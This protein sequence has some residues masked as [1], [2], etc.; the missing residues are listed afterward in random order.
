VQRFSRRDFLRA[1]AA[2]TLTAPLILPGSAF[3]RTAASDRITM[4][5]IGVGG[6]GSWDM[7]AFL[8]QDAVQVVAVCDVDSRRLANAKA[9]VESYYAAGQRSGQYS[10]CAATQDYRQL[11]SREDI[12]AVLI[13][14]PDHT[15]ALIGVEAARRGK[16]IYCEKPLAYSIEEGRAMVETVRRTGRILQT[17]TQRRSSAACRQACEWVLN[18]R[19]GGLHTIRVGLPQ[20]FYVQGGFSGEQPPMPVP[21]GFDYEKWLGPAPWVPY[22]EGRCHFNFRW[23]LDY[24]EGYISDWGAHYLDIAQMGHGTDLTGPIEITAQA[25]FPKEG[26]YDAPTDFH[27]EYVYGDGVRMICATDEVRGMRFE[28]SEGWIHIEKPGEATVIA[29]PETILKS[30]IGPDGIHLPRSTGH[31]SNFIECVLS[32]LETVAPVEVGHRSATVCHLGAIAAQ[33]GRK[34]KWDPDQEHFVGDSGA[35]RWLSGSTREPWHF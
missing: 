33:L 9:R 13:A 21:E 7:Q 3:G 8:A 11:L 29:K 30:P 14:T 25:E 22:T 26:L 16:D 28:G 23:I 27:I 20:G 32:R 24:G 4:G 5:C 15:H 6:Q 31:H 2:A 12:D 18:G 34:L 10:G 17:G 1:A 35:D 19:I